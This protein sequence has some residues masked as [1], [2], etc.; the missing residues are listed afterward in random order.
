[1]SINRKVALAAATTVFLVASISASA[2]NASREGFRHESNAEARIAFQQFLQSQG[3]G[4]QAPSVLF[5][6]KGHSFQC[7]AQLTLCGL[8]ATGTVLSCV[9]DLWTGGAMT[10][11]CLESMAAAGG[12]CA[13][14]SQICGGHTG[15][16]AHVRL[17]L[18]G[19]ATTA[20]PDTTV[21]LGCPSHHRVKTIRTEWFGANTTSGRISRLVMTCTNGTTLTFGYAGTASNTQTCATGDLVTGL[22]VRAGTEI[23]AAGVGCRQTAES[24]APVAFSPLFGGSGGTTVTRNCATDKYVR[25]ARVHMD[26]STESY[27]NIRGIELDCR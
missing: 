3:G 13:V 19:S 7:L 27:P 5:P 18:T 14:A 26:G 15:S 8:G 9:A 16:P 6:H 25:G 1:M 12:A 22:M 20:A 23:V 24:G 21:A 17:A 2:G 10:A 11:V 4:A